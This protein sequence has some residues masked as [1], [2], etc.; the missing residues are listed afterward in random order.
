VTTVPVARLMF[1]GAESMLE[2]HQFLIDNFGLRYF[3]D[4]IEPFYPIKKL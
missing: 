2:T 3:D 1:L 4:F